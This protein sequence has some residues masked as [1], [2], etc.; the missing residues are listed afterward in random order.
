MRLIYG[1]PARNKIIRQLFFVCEAMFVHSPAHGIYF[2][3]NVL[4]MQ[5]LRAAVIAEREVCLHLC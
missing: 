4:A 3:G 5:A 1:H 2:V